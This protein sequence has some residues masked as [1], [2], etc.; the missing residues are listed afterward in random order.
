MLDARTRDRDYACQRRISR[1]R[2]DV[3]IRA[4]RTSDARDQRHHS[5]PKRPA[6]HPA[7]TH[8]IPL[9]HDDHRVRTSMK[10]MF[11]G[12]ALPDDVDITVAATPVATLNRTSAAPPPM[13]D[14][15]TG[16]PG[17]NAAV[18]SGKTFGVENAGITL[19]KFQLG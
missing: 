15:D 5:Q 18:A 19:P 6:L 8:A 11:A 7:T 9:Y 2:L 12:T 4:V 10:S 14:S 17:S 1:A 16:V 13:I 3:R